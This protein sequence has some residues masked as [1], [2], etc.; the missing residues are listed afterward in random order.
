MPTVTLLQVFKKYMFRPID[1]LACF[2]S[3]IK[4]DELIAAYYIFKFI[5]Q[6]VKNNKFYDKYVLD[7]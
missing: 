4:I 7:N 1:Q 3:Q 6:N 2:H 5:L